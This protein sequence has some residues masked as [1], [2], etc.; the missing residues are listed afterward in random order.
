MLCSVRLAGSHV[1]P[2]GSGGDNT[3]VA[4]AGGHLSHVWKMAVA[5]G[6]WF[7][8][9]RVAVASRRV[10]TGNSTASDVGY[11]CIGQLLRVFF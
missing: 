9:L 2:Q 1:T 3:G 4:A 6:K 8:A 10:S 5:A 7:D 11:T